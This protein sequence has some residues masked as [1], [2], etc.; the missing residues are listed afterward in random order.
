[1]QHLIPHGVAQHGHQYRGQSLFGAKLGG[2]DVGIGEVGDEDG[3]DLVIS[4]VNVVLEGEL[5]LLRAGHLVL[6]LYIAEGKK[7]TGMW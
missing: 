1:M 5:R 2:L 4:Q 7:E 3:R 6:K